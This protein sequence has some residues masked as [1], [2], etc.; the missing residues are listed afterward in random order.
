MGFKSWSQSN[1]PSMLFVKSEL[2]QLIQNKKLASMIPGKSY[3]GWPPTF[4]PSPGS[5][6]R[7]G[8]TL[9]RCYSRQ[10]RAFDWSPKWAYCQRSSR[11]AA[12]WP[13]ERDEMGFSRPTCKRGLLFRGDIVVVGCSASQFEW[14][15]SCITFP[16][17]SANITMPKWW[18]ALQHRELFLATCFFRE[19]IY[20]PVIKHG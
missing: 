2:P 1:L 13:W 5:Q 7:R 3:C 9:H 6:S 11:R 10:S 15:L 19:F 14:V 8:L 20:P 16:E 18:C 17:K 12:W 4:S